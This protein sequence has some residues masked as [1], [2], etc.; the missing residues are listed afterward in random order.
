MALVVVVGVDQ[1]H[2]ILGLQF[3]WGM[4][5]MKVGEE[6]ATSVFAEEGGE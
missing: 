6:G 5:I 3:S 4:V 2:Q 1:P